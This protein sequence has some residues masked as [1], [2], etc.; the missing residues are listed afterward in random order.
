MEWKP[1]RRALLGGGLIS[2]LLAF[3]PRALAAVLG[4]PRALAGPMVGAPGPGHFT[5]WVRTS[6]AFDVR[7]EYAR[8]RDFAA[9]TMTAP[10][11]AGPETDYCVILRAENLEPD[12]RY[13]YRLHF[14]GETDRN[15]PLP[16]ATRT[17]PAGAA[18]FRVAFGSCCRLQ[19]DSEQRIFQ[20]VR[21]LE[22]DMFLWL[23]DNI[24]ADSDVP[25]AIADLYRRG[26]VVPALEPLLR[27]TPQLA[28]WDDH[29]FGFN[30]SD[31]Q[32]PF[33]REALALFRQYWANPAG[34]EPGNP[35]IY[36]VQNYGG[37]HFF[38]LDGRYYRDPSAASDGPG[39]SMLGARQKSWLKKQLKASQAP[40]KILASGGG[41]SSAEQ[42][43]G[44]DS[45][46]A[47]MHERNEIFDF[48]RDEQIGGVVCIS[49]DSHMGELNCIPRSDQGGYDI[50]DFCSSPLAQMPATKFVRQMPE[51]RIRDVWSR[52][53]NVGVMQ[54]RMGPQ[55][56]L[57]YTLHDILGEAVWDPLVLTPA[58]LSNGVKSWDRVSD[59]QELKRRERFLRGGG[60]YGP[61][62]D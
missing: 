5:I 17:A 39:K 38:F 49:G 61:D 44:G 27:E 11:Q 60:Y 56:T 41:W 20:T 23:G 25:S 33:K 35:G 46:G 12:T 43:D 34:G 19:F 62:I 59:P 24:Y 13:Y 40:F 28:I 54:F 52:S 4:Y 16:Y 55:P 9:A 31:G 53:V 58:D 47:Y 8:D 2:T 7:L 37:V 57:T 10:V 29:D 21:A 32:S 51:I 1:A 50:Y 22:P 14:A 3:A 48:I 42:E 18:D 30:D 15:Q 26:R 36:F 45:W 6:G